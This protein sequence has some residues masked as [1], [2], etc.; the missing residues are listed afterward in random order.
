[1]L[2]YLSGNGKSELI[3]AAV[4]EL[5]I[6][7]KKLIGKFSLRNFVTKDMRNYAAARYFV[8]DA[9]SIDDSDREFCTALQSFQMMFSARII[10]ILS[11]REDK[12]NLIQQLAAIGVV[13]IVTADTT[14]EITAELLECLSE[15][16]MQRYVTLHEFM[17][18]ETQNEA[19]VSESTVIDE[20]RKYRWNARNIKIAVAGTQHRCG[21][22]VT[23]MNLAYWL[24]ARGADVCYIECNM[25]RHLSTIINLFEAETEKEHYKLEG[26]DCYVTDVLDRD[27][28]FIVYDCGVADGTSTVFHNA[29]KRILC[30]SVLPYELTKFNQ[31][32]K[33]CGK[34]EV[35]PI[36]VAVPDEMRDYCTTLFGDKL[37][38]A[39]S[40][41]SL[42]A[43]NMNSHIYKPLVVEYI[44]E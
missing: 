43:N 11:G 30:G 9:D 18:E 14:D 17:D 37:L 13:N 4:T 33:L 36:A 20:I 23:A 35:V 42:F 7:C 3:D 10:V 32:M 26:I 40:S 12:E 21:T 29:D 41:H 25:N 22:T 31:A 1:M 39:E 24:A 44:K 5:D 8:V 6:G 15:E 38:F 16:G 27:Y 34:L 19:A 28:D 2:L